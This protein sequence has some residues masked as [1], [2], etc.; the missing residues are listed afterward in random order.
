MSHIHPDWRTSCL[1]WRAVST[2]FAAPPM[3]RPISF[4]TQYPDWQRMTL[5]RFF[6]SVAGFHHSDSPGS[7]AVRP[8]ADP[9]SAPPYACHDE[10]KP[11][12][13]SALAG[14]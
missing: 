11:D 8:S 10:R 1:H 7:H 12:M 14:N 4:R 2:A 5:G 13:T 6:W 3:S 9:A